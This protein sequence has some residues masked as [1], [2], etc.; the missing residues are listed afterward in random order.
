MVGKEQKIRLENIESRPRVHHFFVVVYFRA[1]TSGY[2][3]F[4][5]QWDKFI[6]IYTFHR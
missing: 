1:V 5:C 3:R 4:R 6:Y 2:G